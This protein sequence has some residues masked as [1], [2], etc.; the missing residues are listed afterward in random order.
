MVVVVVVRCVGGGG[1]VVYWLGDVVAVGIVIHGAR[2]ER[3]H[4]TAG[5]MAPRFSAPQRRST[6]PMIINDPDAF[7]AVTVTV[8]VRR[9]VVLCPNLLLE[10]VDQ[11]LSV[12]WGCLGLVLLPRCSS[13]S[14]PC[15]GGEE[16]E[17][18]G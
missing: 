8:C 15:E 11:R 6:D 14:E 5:S 10:H 17:Y 12:L 2:C 7:Q 4:A 3:G 16:E 1:G 9:S 18:S 13:S